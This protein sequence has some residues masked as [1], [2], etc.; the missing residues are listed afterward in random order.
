MVKWLRLK[1]TINVIYK[2]R[3]ENF[4]RKSWNS[5]YR[6]SIINGSKLIRW[7]KYANYT[8]RSDFCIIHTE[9]NSHVVTNL[10]TTKVRIWLFSTD[11]RRIKANYCSLWGG[12]MNVFVPNALLTFKLNRITG[13][14][15]GGSNSENYRRM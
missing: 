3:F 2:K 10:G 5:V 6:D 11:F 4:D 15:Q 1:K 8:F 7:R 12:G 13:D 9:Q 14:Y